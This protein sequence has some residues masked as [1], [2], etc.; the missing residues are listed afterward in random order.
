MHLLPWRWTCS[1]QGISV[2]WRSC[3]WTNIWYTDYVF[4]SGPLCAPVNNFPTR[5]PSGQCVDVF[6]YHVV[7]N[8]ETLAKPNPYIYMY[9]GHA[10]ASLF[11]RRI[12][13]CVYGVPFVAKLCEPCVTQSFLIQREANLFFVGTHVR[14]LTVYSTKVTWTHVAHAHKHSRVYFVIHTYLK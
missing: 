13:I 9:S 6:I 8:L 14:P 2:I 3:M 12:S 10:C 1:C 11:S 4:P 7:R 5:A